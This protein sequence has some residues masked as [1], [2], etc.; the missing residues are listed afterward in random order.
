M[1]ACLWLCSVQYR[2]DKSQC[3][4]RLFTEDN[5]STIFTDS[6]G[7]LIETGEGGLILTSAARHQLRCV[8]GHCCR[9]AHCSSLGICATLA[10]RLGQTGR[11]LKCEPWLQVCTR[12]CCKVSTARWTPKPQITFTSRWAVHALPTA[13]AVVALAS[14]SRASLRS[15][16]RPGAR[17]A[18]ARNASTIKPTFRSTKQAISGLT[19]CVAACVLPALQ[20]YSSCVIYPI[21]C[22]CTACLARS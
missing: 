3:T 13:C 12:C 10:P 6:W 19:A 2:E 18:L 14:C 20:A 4:H 5:S 16:P 7:Y 1:A 22:E 15:H 9:P 11:L 17:P 21:L 8:P